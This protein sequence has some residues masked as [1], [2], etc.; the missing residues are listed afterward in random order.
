[1]LSLAPDELR[2]CDAHRHG[3][4]KRFVGQPHPNSVVT[5]S[6]EAWQAF[7]IRGSVTALTLTS[8]FPPVEWKRLISDT[9]SMDTRSS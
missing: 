1:M 7:G 5:S 8:A 6:P 3:E 9:R 4:A 2:Q